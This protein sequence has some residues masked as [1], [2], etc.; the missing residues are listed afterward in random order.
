MKSLF[1][2]EEDEKSD[3]Y[4]PSTIINQLFLALLTW[5]TIVSLLSVD[6]FSEVFPIFQKNLFLKK[7]HF[8]TFI[9]SEVGIV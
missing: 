2:A 6:N 8:H 3:V 4:H 5:W 1:H 9:Y 7:M